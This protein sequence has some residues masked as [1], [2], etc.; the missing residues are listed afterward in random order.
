VVFL[1]RLGAIGRLAGPFRLALVLARRRLAD[2]GRARLVEV[3]LG[4]PRLVG[5]SGGVPAAGCRCLEIIGPQACRAI[6]AL[7]V[8]PFGARCIGI[9]ALDRTR[10]TTLR[11]G[12]A[13]RTFAGTI[14]RGDGD[15]AFARTILGD[16]AGKGIGL[17][18]GDFKDGFRIEDA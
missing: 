13:S 3:G 6:A 15:T 18:R 17:L 10:W 9:V 14:N 4:W 16:I 1:D 12:W 7:A 5:I 8:G 2:L 11:R